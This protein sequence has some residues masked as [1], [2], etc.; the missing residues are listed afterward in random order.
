VEK[1]GISRLIGELVEEHGELIRFFGRYEERA[2]TAIAD[3]V[4][5]NPQEM[6]LAGV[7]SALAKWLP[8][9]KKD[10]FS[11]DQ[12]RGDANGDGLDGL[13]SAVKNP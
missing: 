12:R 2:P 5:G 10:L 13:W 9:K 8:P 6:P 7:V 11:G 4:A 1:S 3:F